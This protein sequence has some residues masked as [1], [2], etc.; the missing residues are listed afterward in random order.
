MLASSKQ[1]EDSMERTPWLPGWTDRD[2]E[3]ATRCASQKES[4]GQVLRTRP[5]LYHGRRTE[6]EEKIR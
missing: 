6:T 2:R 3:I 5:L 4:V 1:E